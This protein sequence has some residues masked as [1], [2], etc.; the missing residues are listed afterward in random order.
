MFKSTDPIV[1]T[2]E[3]RRG[4]ERMSRS[5]S[6]RSERVRRAQII[7]GVADG[8]SYASLKAR[9]RTSSPTIA[10]WVHRNA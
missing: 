2:T 8:E 6:A 1:L 3:E 9:L 5:R 10:R 4:L 7:L